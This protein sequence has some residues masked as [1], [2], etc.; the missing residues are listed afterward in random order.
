MRGVPLSKLRFWTNE[1]DEDFDFMSVTA[2]DINAADLKHS[3]RGVRLVLSPLWA[4]YV[5]S[6]LRRAK[7]SNVD[8]VYKLPTGGYH[9]NPYYD[10]SIVVSLNGFEP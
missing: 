5:P 6:W 2:L 3:Q 10:V 9:D 1:S 4:K 8:V 7:R